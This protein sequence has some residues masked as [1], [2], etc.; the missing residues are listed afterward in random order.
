MYSSYIYIIVVSC[1]DR[2]FR[3]YR[4]VL[5]NLYIRLVPVRDGGMFDSVL[6]IELCKGEE[7]HI[8]Q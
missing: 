7:F 3:S 2:S 5:T 6:E 4:V 1:F 8:N